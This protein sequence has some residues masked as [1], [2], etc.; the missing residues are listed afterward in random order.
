MA[1]SNN[2]ISTDWLFPLFFL[3]ASFYQ[4]LVFYIFFSA[5]FFKLPK[6]AGQPRWTWTY[7]GRP[8]W[9][10]ADP[11]RPGLTQV[12]S[13]G[14]GRTRINFFWRLIEYVEVLDYQLAALRTEFIRPSLLCILKIAFL[15][16]EPKCKTK[17]KKIH[18]NIY[19][20]GFVFYAES[21][22]ALKKILFRFFGSAECVEG[23]FLVLKNIV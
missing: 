3:F 2:R 11:I 7:P 17:Q 15:I 18:T 6:G 1:A 9:T 10:Q 5:S 14:P 20:L 13:D 21:L 22:H 16:R 23:S 19:E 8:G 4:L 12:D